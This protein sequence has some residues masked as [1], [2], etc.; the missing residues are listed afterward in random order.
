MDYVSIGS[1]PAGEE[2]AQVG[3]DNYSHQARIEGKIFIQQ[4]KRQFGEHPNA[5]FK[6]KSFPHD[7]GS[8][9]EVVVVFNDDNEEACNFAYNVEANTPEFWDDEAKFAFERE[10]IGYF[11]R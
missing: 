8:Y 1:T 3:S 4:L 2:C 10:K 7:F 11:G 9:Y 5:Y 6:L